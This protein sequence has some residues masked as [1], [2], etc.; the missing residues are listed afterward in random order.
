[1]KF[2]HYHPTATGY[3][4]FFMKSILWGLFKYEKSY[5]VNKKITNV[6]GAHSLS[7]N[8]FILDETRKHVK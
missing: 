8:I 4:V 1:M 5:W 6:G 2:S 7:E 3:R